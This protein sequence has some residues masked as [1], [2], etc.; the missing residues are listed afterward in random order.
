MLTDA[1]QKLR[2]SGQGVTRGHML[3]FSHVINGRLGAMKEL[4][5][6]PHP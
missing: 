5:G 1:N 4:G 2:A 3:L 6:P